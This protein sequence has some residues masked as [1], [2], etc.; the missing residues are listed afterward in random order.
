MARTT[1]STENA[2]HFS[3]SSRATVHAHARRSCAR[4]SAHEQRKRRKGIRTLSSLRG[5]LSGR[6][7]AGK[8]RPAAREASCGRGRGGV[9]RCGLE[10]RRRRRPCRVRAVYSALLAGGAG[11]EGPRRCC[12]RRRRASASARVIAIHRPHSRM[13]AFGACDVLR[14][15]PAA[16]CRA[17]I[18]TPRSITR[19]REPKADST[20]GARPS[21]KTGRRKNASTE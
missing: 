5:S 6:G 21:R 18:F 20:A 11:R 1:T 2:R 3:S 7:V 8:Q 10:R 4:S 16:A 9:A 15:T 19:R 13:R 12:R 14:I 17:G